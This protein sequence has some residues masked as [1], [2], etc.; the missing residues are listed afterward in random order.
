MSEQSS[1]SAIF[2]LADEI[3]DRLAKSDPLFATEAGIPGY[4]HLLP[5]F[6]IAKHRRD[7]A[8]IVRDLQ[9]L[10]TLDAHGDVDRI[11][12]AVIRERLSVKLALYE[13]DE[14]RRTFS[15]LNSPVAAI[16]QVFEL[17]P[18]TSAERSEERR[19]GKECR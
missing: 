8:Q 11:A 15:V 10:E 13:A 14:E 7:Q 1:Q 19:V 5:D 2:T 16:R 9:T 18:L 4:D 6:S 12:A 17:M 3:V